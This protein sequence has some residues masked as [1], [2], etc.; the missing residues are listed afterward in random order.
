V[1]GP[2]IGG[3]GVEEGLGLGLGAHRTA[4]GRQAQPG[5]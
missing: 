4:E 3:R 5:L 2:F 1:S